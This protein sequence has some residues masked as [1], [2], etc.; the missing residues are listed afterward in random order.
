MDIQARV[1]N[2][3]IP[4]DAARDIERIV[5]IWQSARAANHSQGKFLFGH[6]TI[7]DA[8]FVPVATRF[9]TY[10]V[11]LSSIIEDYVNTIIEIPFMQ[12]WSGK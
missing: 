3:A 8:M 1:S 2:H 11:K 6:F 5:Q 12:E 9:V 10:Q 7:A 4:E